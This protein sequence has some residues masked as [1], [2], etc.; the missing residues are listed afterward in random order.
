MHDVIWMKHMFFQPE[1]TS[2]EF[3][4]DSEPLTVD[5]KEDINVT[6][7]EY[8]IAVSEKNLVCC[9]TFVDKVGQDNPSKTAAWEGEVNVKVTRSSRISRPPE[10]LIDVQNFLVEMSSMLG[11]LAKIQYLK[12]TPNLDEGKVKLSVVEPGMSM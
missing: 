6:K 5:V 1:Q 9:V 12:L 11:M 3:K 2:V 10:H 8:I 7:E 4:L